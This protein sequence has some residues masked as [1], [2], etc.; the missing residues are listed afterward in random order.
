MSLRNLDWDSP[1]PHICGICD[2]TCTHWN[3][4]ASVDVLRR[5]FEPPPSGWRRLA[6]GLRP[7][8]WLYAHLFD[9]FDKPVLVDSS[10]ALSWVR[11]QIEASRS[12][13]DVD[14]YL[15]YVVRDGRAVTNSYYRKYPE[16]GIEAAVQRWASPTREMDTF[17]DSYDGEKH[18]LRYG[19]LCSSPEPNIQA[20]CDF[21]GIDF[22][23]QMLEYWKQEHHIIGGNAG[24]R[25]LI[26]NARVSAPDWHEGE[27]YAELEQTP[28]IRL[29]LRWRN[30][31]SAE[32]LAVFERLAGDL[33]RRYAFDG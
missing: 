23:P 5:Y 6:S 7:N 27:F 11:Q 26:E 25:S 18:R 24:T 29:D 13:R 31:L 32:H 20:L 12:A 2:D 21:I 17:F 1:S 16:Q 15:L 8:P 28:G 9:W 19:I 4:R 14:V 30:E 33:N 3:D 22:E 10:K